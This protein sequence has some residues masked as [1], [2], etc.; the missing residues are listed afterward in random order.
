MKKILMLAV[1]AITLSGCTESQA[2]KQSACRVAMTAY[3]FKSEECTAQPQ[4]ECLATVEADHVCEFVFTSMARDI[5][6]CARDIPNGECSSLPA[7]CL[8]IK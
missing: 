3:C 8:S 5:L 1:L 4:A 6:V 2:T 7:S